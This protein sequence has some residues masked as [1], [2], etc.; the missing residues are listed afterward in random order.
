MRGTVA[1][2]MRVLRTARHG[3]HGG[4]GDGLFDGWSDGS[5]KD[6]HLNTD[7]LFL[8]VDAGGT[9]TTAVVGTADLT[10]LALPDGTAGLDALLDKP[11]RPEPVNAWLC[12]GVTCLAPMSD[13]VHL[14]KAPKE[15]A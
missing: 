14:K 10:V 12:R 7:N 6:G 15:K 11:A 9:H 5:W 8:G 2:G 1:L 13:L 4:S 3:A